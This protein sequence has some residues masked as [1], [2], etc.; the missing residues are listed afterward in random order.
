M[1][2]LGTS[3]EDPQSQGLLALASG[4][5]QGN[6]G[7]GV[8]DMSTTMVGAQDTALKRKL[9]ELLLQKSGME[10]DAEKLKLSDD[11]TVR[12]T[13]TEAYKAR[14]ALPGSA[15]AASAPRAA[16][17]QGAGFSPAV[18]S[19]LPVEFQT[20]TFSAMPGSSAPSMPSQA[21]NAIP[22]KSNNFQVYSD[23]GDQLAA[24]GQA[25]AAQKYYEMAD[26]FRPKYNTTPQNLMVNGKLTPVLIA[27][28]GSTKDMNGYAVKPDM[29]EQS[30]G[31]TKTWID[32]NSLTPGASLTMKPTPG[33]VM[34][35]QRSRS[36]QAAMIAKDYKVAGLNPDGSPTGDMETTAR[37]IASGQLPAPTGMALTNPRN[38]KM[39]ARV[40][41]LNPQY[42]FT[43]VTAKKTAA[44]AFTSGPQGNALRSFAVAGNHLDQ[45]GT[46]VDAMGN[47]DL[48]V[49][50]TVANAYAKQ[51]GSTAPTN[52]AAAKEV[53]SK[54]VIKAIVG[55]GGGVEERKELALLMDA[56]RS[57]AQLKGV[58]KQFRDLMGAQHDALLIQRRAAGLPDST[59]PNY[60]AVD[61][62]PAP[63][64]S[65]SWGIQKVQ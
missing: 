45:L 23:L 34:S 7:K 54:E 21:T 30:D 40:M 36:N 43:D 46:L 60:N 52:F 11:A 19:S 56:A 8:S 13:L 49:I 65:G 53:V 48:N 28:D 51:T 15:S 61:T 31:A 5:M 32:K 6:I 29:V 12:Q 20:P 3:W 4:L 41:E 25:A 59:L 14:G 10:L 63:A 18:M 2:L 26:K 55:G 58:I 1:G 33:E 9:N 27:E 42:D 64:S 50:N 39:L 17:G 62:Q 24:K 35:D 38:Q 57:P 37:A 22:P 47:R 16:L 44:T